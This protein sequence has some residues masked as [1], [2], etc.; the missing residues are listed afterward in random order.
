MKDYCYTIHKE[1]RQTIQRQTFEGIGT[2][3]ICENRG[4]K[5]AEVA[6]MT[7]YGNYCFR[8]E[9]T[10]DICM[11]LRSTD[12]YLMDKL[13]DGHGEKR[14]M[15]AEATSENVRRD[16]RLKISEGADRA[17]ERCANRGRSADVDERVGTGLGG[18]E[19]PLRIPLQ[20]GRLPVHG[21]GAAS[22][23]PEREGAGSHAGSSAA[24]KGAGMNEQSDL[25]AVRTP[26][27]PAMAQKMPEADAAGRT[28]AKRLYH[29]YGGCSRSGGADVHGSFLRMVAWALLKERGLPECKRQ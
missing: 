25:C 2:I 17:L 3:I 8:W 12:D 7:E 4:A 15:D 5:C 29:S 19:T 24:L 13:L 14:V 16:A 9:D 22:H 27:A 21:T 1:G 26:K 20:R 6:A 18:R 10:S 28:F 11:V 23:S